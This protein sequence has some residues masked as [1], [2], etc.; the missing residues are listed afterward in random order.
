MKKLRLSTDDLRVETFEVP[1]RGVEDGTVGG[2]GAESTARV[3]TYWPY[4]HTE[5]LNCTVAGTCLEDSCGC[6]DDDLC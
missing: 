2:H 1:V 5:R 4:C 6:S 3:C